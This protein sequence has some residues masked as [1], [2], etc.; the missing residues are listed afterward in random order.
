[1]EGVCVFGVWEILATQGRHAHTMHSLDFKVF[2][3]VAGPVLWNRDDVHSVDGEVQ[4]WETVGIY[5]WC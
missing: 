2:P 3:G 5:S 1:M 4:Q